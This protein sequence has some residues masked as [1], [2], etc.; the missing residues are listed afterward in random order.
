MRR[1]IDEGV[2]RGEHFIQYGLRGCWPSPEEFEWMEK[3][4]MRWHSADSIAQRGVEATLRCLLEQ[5]RSLPSRVFLSIDIDVLDPAYGPGTGTPEPG[6]LTSRE[7]LRVV[8]RVA[9]EMDLVAVELVEVSPPYDPS[10]I[11]ALVAQRCLI[12]VL[13]GMAY[14]RRSGRAAG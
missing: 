13:A 2:V 6:G 11:T 7:L 8:R 4:G 10:G 12:E 14:R 9:M 5:A 3:V 1:V